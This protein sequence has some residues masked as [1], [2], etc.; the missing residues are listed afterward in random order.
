MA[1]SKKIRDIVQAKYNGL[2]AYTGKELGDDWQVDHIQSQ[3]SFEQVLVKE[4]HYKHRETKQE[5]SIDAYQ[6]MFDELLANFGKRDDNFIAVYDYKYIPK[7]LKPHPDCHR[8]ENL[9]P[10][11]RIVNHYKREKDLEQFRH[12]MLSFHLR[13][14]TLPKRTLVESTKRRIEYM[15]TIADLFHISRNKPFNGKFYFETL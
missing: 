3:Y 13:L 10:A 2:C 14:A 15:N 6:I 7:K 5:I 12:Y 11:I 8:I 4:A 9:I 1:F